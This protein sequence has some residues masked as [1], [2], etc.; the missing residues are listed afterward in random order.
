MFGGLPH[1]ELPL[2]PAPVLVLDQRKS[3]SYLP[4]LNTQTSRFMTKEHSKCNI[5]TATQG[6]FKQH[7]DTASL[8]LSKYRPKESPEPSTEPKPS[9][10]PAKVQRQETERK[11]ALPP[12][13]EAIMISRELRHKNSSQRFVEIPRQPS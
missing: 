4:Y 13:L 11:P 8:L 3:K 2:Q 7:E 6:S 10:P 1:V 5:P 12:A 9:A